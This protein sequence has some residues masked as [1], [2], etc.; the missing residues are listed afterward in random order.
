MVKATLP[1]LSRRAPGLKW[2]PGLLPQT[3][4]DSP[5]LSQL[6]QSRVSS[7]PCALPGA[8]R[9]SASANLGKASMNVRCYHVIKLT[10]VENQH[11]YLKVKV[12]SKSNN[13]KL[14]TRAPHAEAL[15]RCWIGTISGSELR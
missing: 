10:C 7:Y 5:Y 13:M 9:I 4:T 15:K 8:S 12:Q 6:C 11:F 3:M 2:I 14:V 1:N